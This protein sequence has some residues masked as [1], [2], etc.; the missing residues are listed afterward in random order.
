V[1]WWRQLKLESAT[2]PVGGDSIA[3]QKKN[4]QALSDLGVLVETTELEKD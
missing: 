1:F 4:T 3:E 2:T